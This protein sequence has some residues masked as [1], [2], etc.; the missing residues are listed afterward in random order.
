MSDALEPK[1]GDAT[2]QENH[3]GSPSAGDSTVTPLE[4][5]A[6]SVAEDVATLENHAGGTPKD[7]LKP[8]ENHAGSEKA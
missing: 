4:N 8:Q 1:T 3:A 5:H 6:G 7:L 2:T